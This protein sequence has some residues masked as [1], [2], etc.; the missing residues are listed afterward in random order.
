MSSEAIKLGNHAVE[1]LLSGDVVQ[2]K[3]GGPKMTV[4][5]SQVGDVTAVWFVPPGQPMTGKFP[6][7]VLT[8]VPPEPKEPA[9]AKP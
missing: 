8:K 7:D 2:L 4:V 9:E 5:K 3:S 6:A 1:Q